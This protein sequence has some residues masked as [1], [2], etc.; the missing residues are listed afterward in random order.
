MGL[1]HL[2]YS[3]LPCILFNISLE[4]QLDLV[5]LTAISHPPCRTT[6]LIIFYPLL[7]LSILVNPLLTSPGSCTQDLLIPVYPIHDFSKC[8]TGIFSLDAGNDVIHDSCLL[9]I[10]L[11]SI[12]ELPE[13]SLSDPSHMPRKIRFWDVIS[14]DVCWVIFTPDIL[15]INIIFFHH[16]PQKMMKNINVLCTN[17][18]L[19]VFLLE[20]SRLGY[21]HK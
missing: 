18:Y 21:P 2:F 9:D 12:H 4:S 19:P 14:H 8:V 16:V 20:K 3:C 5:Q 7:L 6:L 15:D 11:S 1:A 17:T 10:L 13:F